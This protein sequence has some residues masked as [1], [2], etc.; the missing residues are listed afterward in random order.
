[1]LLVTILLSI[2]LGVSLVI[3]FLLYRAGI[4]KLEEIEFNNESFISLESWVS[5]LKM[6]ILKTYAHIKILDDKQMFEK[7][8]EVGIVFQD[9][10]NLISKLNEK[11][12]EFE[13]EEGE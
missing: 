13:E 2:F 5:E 10:V 7:D 8:D 12:K 9:M 11:S 4:N 6:E 1:M 3:N